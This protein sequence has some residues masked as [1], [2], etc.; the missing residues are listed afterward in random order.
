M[1]LISLAK[2]LAHSLLIRLATKKMGYTIKP[3][4]KGYFN[5]KSTIKKAEEEGLSVAEY[6]E[7]NNIGK[8]GRNRESIISLLNSKGYII[9]YD[10]ILEIGAGTGIYLERFLELCA[11]A[12]YE[13]YE[14]DLGWSNYLRKKYSDRGIEMRVHQS[15]GCTLKQSKDNTV[16]LIIAHGVFVYLP[17]VITFHY[18]IEAVRVCKQ[19]GRIV[20][21]CFTD[22]TFTV[23]EIIRFREVNPEYDFPVIISEATLFEFCDR[24]N[25]EI[26]GFFEAPYHLT[27]TTYYVIKKK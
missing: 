26:E 13:V 25:L 10:S 21:D 7:K 9:K 14:P 18:L 11:P 19:N 12:K 23:D 20:F 5:A 4:G 27:N 3:I 17:I 22:C 2:S 16:D 6:L 1:K 15:D 8:V 24:F